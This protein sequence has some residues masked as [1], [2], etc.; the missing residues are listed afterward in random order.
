MA[1]ETTYNRAPV[2]IVELIQP[3]CSNRFGTSPCT[4]TGTPKCYNCYWTCLDRDNYNTDGSITWRLSRP[5]DKVDWLYEE[6]DANNIKT[7][8]LPMLVAASHTS[9]RINPGA[10]RTGE[11]PLGRRATATITV[12]NAVWD[13]HVGDFYLADR[14]ARPSVGFWTLFTA[15]N[16]D[17][18][19]GLEAVIYEGYEGQTLAEMQSRRFNVE[20]ISGPDG[21]DRYTISCRDPLDDIRGKNAKYPPTS[22]ISLTSE[23]TATA[24]DI[25]VTCLESELDLVLGN[26]S[27]KYV[28]IGEE[29]IRYTGYTGTE[30]ELTLTGVAR[31][32]FGT[33]AEEHDIDAAVQRGAYHLNQ[34]LYKVAQYILEDHTTVKNSYIDGTQWD[35]EGNSYL[36]T[37]NCTTFIPTPEP[38]E[39]LL[40]ELCRDGLFSIYWDDR[41]QTI[42]LLAVRPPKETPL[43]WSD[44][45][46]LSGFNQTVKIDD[47]M[48]RVTIFFGVKNWQEDL[49]EP[50]NFDNRR[51]R[52]DA[53]VETERAAGGKIVENTIFSRW[54]QTFGNA[55]LVGSSMLLR[56][57]LPPKYLTLELDAKDRSVAIGDV[58]DLTTRHIRDIE[59]NL[60]ETRWQVIGVDEPQPGSRIRVELQSYQFVGKF[61]IIMAND[62]PDYATATAEEKLNGCWIAENTGVMPDGSDPYLLQ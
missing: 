15:R 9:S 2:V 43:A 14:A 36:S 41:A 23:I 20:Q 51:I 26:T 35:D 24:T 18:Y 19:P 31:G 39:N 33:V 45:N 40:G 21:Q 62:A 12:Q 13:D 1:D 58:V 22:Q 34:Q 46:N 4:A 11:S 42:P 10:A 54:T 60:V 37:L 30:P 3:R 50:R 32:A 61:A 59:G 52:V 7:N 29:I 17:Y 47:R 25:P 8:A 49:S 38:V 27:E 16:K 48:T 56:Y 5:Q 6:T 53:E 44:D 55:L 28:V 57:R